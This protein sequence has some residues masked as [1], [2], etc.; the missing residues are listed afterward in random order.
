MNLDKNTN[1]IK[2][3]RKKKKKKLQLDNSTQKIQVPK[4]NYTLN[5]LIHSH[6]K[7]KHSRRSILECSL[8]LFQ[9]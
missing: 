4:R 6:S 9:S 8:S 2:Y 1:S 5:H 7:I 3:S